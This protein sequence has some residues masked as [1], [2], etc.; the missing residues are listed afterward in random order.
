MLGLHRQVVRELC[1]IRPKNVKASQPVFDVPP[2][3][4]FKKDLEAAGIVY[5]DDRNRRADFHS[6]R[7]SFATWNALAGTPLQVTK[8]LMRHSDVKLTDGVY[9]HIQHLQT[10]E[11]INRLPTIEAPSIAPSKIDATWPVE[12]QTGEDEEAL[13]CNETTG[14]GGLCPVVAQTDAE[15]EWCRRWDS[16]PHGFLR[17]IL[18]PV[19]LPISPLRQ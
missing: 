11:A 15:R 19:R 13:A 12:S 7:H 2:I 1:A 9:T 3:E 14:I 6:L 18:N 5:L 17:G 10:T 16:N 8:Q 4:Q